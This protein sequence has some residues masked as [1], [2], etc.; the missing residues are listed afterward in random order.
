MIIKRIVKV[1]AIVAFA[2][3]FAGLAA[4]QIPFEQ[5]DVPGSTSAIATGI[6]NLNQVVGWYTTNNSSGTGFEFQNGAFMNLNVSVPGADVLST[7]P[8]AINDTGTIAGVFTGASGP[9][10]FLLNGS[11]YS[12]VAGPAGSIEDEATAIDNSGD[13]AGWDVNGS[14]VTQGFILSG[15]A[16]TTIAV[17]GATATEITGINSAGGA[18]VGITDL[19]TGQQAGFIYDYGA[20]N[21]QFFTFNL[22]PALTINSMS[23][24]DSGEIACTYAGINGL[25]H[26]CISNGV[27]F[28]TVDDLNGVGTT[29]LTGI[30]DSGF[31]VGSFVDANGVT[32]GIV[33][34]PEASTVMLF[35]VGLLGVAL[36]GAA[37][38]K[39][40]PL[41]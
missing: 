41:G 32:R 19:F 31:V 33:S 35:G 20:T 39:P 17:P 11:G 22:P 40:A 13:V 14:S 30:N 18:V 12:I 15:G 3:G 21:P 24:N 29:S 2:L 8:L 7:Q 37:R 34:T 26:G 23:I 25:T 10:G 16:Y 9:E 36:A 1:A 28:S 27:T 4:A 5:I 38:R 6:N